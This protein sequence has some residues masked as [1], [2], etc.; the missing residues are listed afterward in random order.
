MDLKVTNFELDI[1]TFIILKEQW[2]VG[3]PMGSTAWFSQ[4][5]GTPFSSKSKASMLLTRSLN[6]FQLHI[7]TSSLSVV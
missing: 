3:E 6:Y 1:L 4:L 5:H 7:I 2:E